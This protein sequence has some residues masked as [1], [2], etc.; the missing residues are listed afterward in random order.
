M[1]TAS[2]KGTLIR[3]FSIAQDDQE[4]EGGG[5]GGVGG[6]CV[7]SMVSE[8][9]RGTQPA[10]IYSINFSPDSRLLCASSS[11][12]TIHVFAVSDAAKNKQAPFMARNPSLNGMLPKY[13]RWASLSPWRKSGRQGDL[14]TISLR[15]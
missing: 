2:D 11:H 12:G 15:P 7:G 14:C 1:A 3:V 9:R 5:G 6:V 8:L 4:G 10:L 13:F